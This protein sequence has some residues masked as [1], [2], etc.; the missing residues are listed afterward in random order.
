[1]KTTQ[2]QPLSRHSRT[3]NSLISCY[4]L[5]DLGMSCGKYTWSNNQTPPTLERLD[6][7]LVSKSWEDLFP[8]A[9][10]YKLPREM[11]DHN[12]LILS[13]SHHQPLRKLDFRFELSWLKDR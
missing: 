4:D 13:T 6:R 1:M 9:M 12:P 3:F 10:V 2:K 5:I 11:S 8:R 7:I